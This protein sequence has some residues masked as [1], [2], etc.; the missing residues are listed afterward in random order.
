[1]PQPKETQSQVSAVVYNRHAYLVVNENQ[2]SVLSYCITSQES[3]PICS[4]LSWSIA[5]ADPSAC[6][7]SLACTLLLLSAS[8]NTRPLTEDP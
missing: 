6:L 7:D 8:P 5:S 2:R 3:G 1:M 4:N